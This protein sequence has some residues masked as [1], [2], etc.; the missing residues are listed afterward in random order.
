M[1]TEQAD[2]WLHRAAAGGDAQALHLLATV[3][4]TSGSVTE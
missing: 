3:S 1:D 2:L 4:Y